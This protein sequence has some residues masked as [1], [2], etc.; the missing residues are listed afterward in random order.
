[1][2][3]TESMIISIFLAGICPLLI[4]A[5]CWWTAAIV[6]MRVPG[7]SVNAVIVSAISGLV[8]GFILDLVLLRRWVR[9]FYTASLW[10]LAAVYGA[11]SW[12]SRRVTCLGPL[13]SCWS[14][15]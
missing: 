3:K 14:A 4:C 15:C 8:I 9:R 13:G 10:W 2:S 1:M 12:A 7:V 5:V 6:Q 11:R